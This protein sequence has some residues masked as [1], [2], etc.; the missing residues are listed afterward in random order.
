[1]K[2]IFVFIAIQQIHKYSIRNDNK[3]SIEWR[4]QCSETRK[5]RMIKYK[6]VASLIPKIK[7]NFVAS[8]IPPMHSW[9]IDED[10]KKTVRN[11]LGWEVI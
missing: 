3:N 2:I 8:L 11:I 7:S 9:N 5:L 4:V 6:F 1:M 10:G